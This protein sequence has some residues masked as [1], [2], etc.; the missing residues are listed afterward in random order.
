MN[1]IVLSFRT[2]ECQRNLSNSLQYLSNIISNV[3]ITIL[4]I[5]LE[6]KRVPEFPEL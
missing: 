2:T 3:M 4:T 5:P 6:N 1:A